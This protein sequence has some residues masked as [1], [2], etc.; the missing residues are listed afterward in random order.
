MG[1]GDHFNTGDRSGQVQ[2]AGEQSTLTLPPAPQG[3]TRAGT[4][5]LCSEGTAIES[6]LI[7]YANGG[8]AFRP[9]Q[10]LDL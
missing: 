5:R 8:T 9:P 6:D 4:G 3:L 1:G 2:E 7:G 10:T